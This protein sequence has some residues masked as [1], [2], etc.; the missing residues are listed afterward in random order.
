MARKPHVNPGKDLEARMR[1]QR[2]APVVGKYPAVQSVSVKLAFEDPAGREHP[3][4]RGMVYAD[5]MHLFFDFPCPLRDCQKGG[6]NAS[7][8]LL[9]ALALHRNA[10]S[11]TLTCT[12]TRQRNGASERCNL[13]LNYTMSV[14]GKAAAAA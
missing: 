6:F 4:P 10:H 12:G 5:D 3:S 9:H 14:R 2:A 13:Q 1:R 11:G 8:D 7:A